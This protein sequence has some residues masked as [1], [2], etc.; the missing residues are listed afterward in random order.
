VSRITK[1]QRWLDLI[2]ALVARHYP[3][4]K[5]ALL[6]ELPA[7]RAMEPDS[8][9]RVFERDKA[10][11]VELGIPIAYREYSVD[12]EPSA[13]GYFLSK[14][15]FFLPYLR[16]VGGAEA[17]LE[18][19][20]TLRAG[21]VELAPEHLTDALAA[22]R[23]VADLPASPLV[24]EART[25]FAKLVLDLDALPG[26]DVPVHIADPPGAPAIRSLLEVLSDA[27]VERRPVKFV[28]RGIS[29]GETTTRTV[30]PYGLLVLGGRWYL[31]GHDRLR[32][33]LREFRVDRMES[34]AAVGARGSVRAPEGFSL[35]VYARRPAWELDDEREAV[36]ARVRFAFPWSLWAE[37]NGYGDLVAREDGGAAVRAFRVRAPDPFLRWLLSSEAELELLGPPDFVGELRA[38]AASV[39]ALHDR[40]PESD[41]EA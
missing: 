22:L 34:A 11:L 9:G 3:I 35:E 36:E 32:G 40:V 13:P 19:R 28:Y 37:R 38:L 41:A 27:L 2:S 8:A 23:R 21:S 15:D 17:P 31:V 12:G 10:D 18:R 5:A 33:A 4:E 6:E 24:H 30:D 16:L 25:A 39:A 1:T 7:Y 14:H 20:G 29:R 26:E